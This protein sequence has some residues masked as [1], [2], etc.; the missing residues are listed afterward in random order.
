MNKC[1]R[2]ALWPFTPH[3]DRKKRLTISRSWILDLSWRLSFSRRCSL[4]ERVR[5]ASSCS[6]NM[7]LVSNRT[8]LSSFSSYQKKHHI[9]RGYE[10]KSK[11]KHC[12][13]FKRKHFSEN[14]HHY[15]ELS[16]ITITRSN[17]IN[18]SSLS[19]KKGNKISLKY[20]VGWILCKTSIPFKFFPL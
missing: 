10:F 4:S 5:V 15:F 20:S 17:S 13:P 12:S 14:V 2:D 18:S 1:C 3:T 6:S 11:H 7:L 19:R 8:W 9:N 16:Y